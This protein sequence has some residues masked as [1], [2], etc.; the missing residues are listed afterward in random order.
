MKL[1]F[2]TGKLKNHIRQIN[3]RYK[4]LKD[5]KAKYQVF[6]VTNKEGLIKTG[7]IASDDLSNYIVIGGR[8]FV[9]NPYRVNVGS[10]GLSDE[11]LKGLVSPA[12]V[13]FETTDDLDSEFLF[14][15]LK[16]PLGLN[17]IKWYGNRGGVRSALR[18]KD[19]E[20]IDIPDLTHEQQLNVLQRLKAV[21]NVLNGLS[22]EQEKQ[23]NLLTQ[24][25]Q[26]I[27]QEAL[28]GKLVPQDPNDEPASELLK[29]IKAEKERL[30]AEGK[31]KK[32]KPLPLVSKEEIPYELPGGWEWLRLGDV[33]ELTSGQHIPKSGY[34]ETGN[35]Y[36]YLT[37]PADFGK[38]NP[39][40][41]KWT[42]KPKVLAKSGD[43]LLTV[44]GSG[45]GK[46]NYL[47]LDDVAISRQLMAIRPFSIRREFLYLFLSAKFTH[48]QNQKVGI[49][50]PGI[51]RKDVLHL[52]IPLPSLLE[53][54]RIV[55]QVDKLMKLCDELEA[56]LTS[57]QKDS[58]MLIQAVLQEAFGMEQL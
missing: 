6:G 15:Y 52:L 54:K 5:E 1:S 28:E 45:I 41:T 33:I 8:Q 37:G 2:P 17:L 26:A 48:F 53:Q 39:I 25:R 14:Y 29:R 47:H 58:E 38:K 11:K 7:N 30:I 24:L 4:D 57:S 3:L 44:K 51:S 10:L 43:I 18:Y 27:L 31:I 34:N 42:T 35:G 21:D 50:I 32:Q 12:Y 23:S 20:K 19:L 49:A 46:I 55:A 9:Y 13:V 36:P 56:Q 40:I 16:S 22:T